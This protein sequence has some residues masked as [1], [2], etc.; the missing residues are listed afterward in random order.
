MKP[1][2]EIR[3][4][5][6]RAELTTHPQTHEKVFQDVLDAQQ[7]TVAP[8]P[9]RPERWRSVMR[10]PI[11]KYAVAALIVLAAIVGLSLFRETTNVAWAIEQS[12]EALSKYRALVLEGSASQRAWDEDGSQELQPV[13]MWAVADPNQTRIEKYRFELDGV[14]MLATDGRKTWKY[15]PQAHR[16]TI[17]N[18]PYVAAEISLGSRFLQQLK[19]FRDSGVITHW[20]ETATDDSETGKQRVLLSIAWQD[21]RWNGPRSMRLE[22]DRQSKLLVGFEQWEN[23][24]WQ[25]PPTVVTEKITYY[26]TLPDDLFKL[27]IP[28]GATVVEE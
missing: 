1:A 3:K 28:P 24:D 15:E 7:A 17:R 8:S 27:E 11:T 18:H 21:A 5:F 19:E 16:L 6:D 12:I 20:Q 9:A 13:K 10:H 4:L 14:P 25:G 22:F 26:E 2:D 23:A